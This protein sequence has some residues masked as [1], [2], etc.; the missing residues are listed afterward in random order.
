MCQTIPIASL[1]LARGSSLARG[2]IS[3]R[4]WLLRIG[5][6]LVRVREYLQS[7]GSD[8]SSLPAELPYELQELVLSRPRRTSAVTQQVCLNHTALHKNDIHSKQKLKKTMVLFPRYL[9]HHS[10]TIYPVRFA[11]I[12]FS[13]SFY[14]SQKYNMQKSHW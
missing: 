2:E 12:Y 1:S 11:I 8:K 5:I 13:Q 9:H 10:E 14:K 7:V 4:N 3:G 6:G